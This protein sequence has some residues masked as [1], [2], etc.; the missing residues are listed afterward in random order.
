MK[1]EE[2]RK[3]L[4]KEVI[5]LG[6]VVGV[7]VA[8][9]IAA[10]TW[11]ASIQQEKTQISGQASQQQGTISEL[12]NKIDNSGNAA[13]LYSKVAHERQNEEFAIDNDKVREVLQELVNQY[14]LQVNDKLEYSSEKD[15]QSPELSM[16]TSAVKVR[17]ETRLKFSAI[18]DVHAYG[19]IEALSQKLPGIIKIN[20]FSI[21]RKG[22]LDSVALNE[23]SAGKL[24]NTV[25]VEIVFDWFSIEP[26]SEKTDAGANAPA[27]MGAP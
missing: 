24:A 13:K 12:R 27:P 7:A 18:S 14:R 5:K 23:L 25:D 1:L 6:V 10:S 21:V 9:Y 11:S 2:E 20:Q 17:Q 3:Q 16:L 19:F 4:I 22:R 26:K 15:L 8:L